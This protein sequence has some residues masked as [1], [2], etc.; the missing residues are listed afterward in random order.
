MYL[1]PKERAVGSALSQLGL[2]VGAGLAPAFTVY[3]AYHHNWRWAFFCA[4]ILGLLWIPIWLFTSKAIPPGAPPPAEKFEPSGMIADPRLW[5]LMIANALS[6]VFYTLWTNWAPTY[7]VR[8]HHLTPQEAA[9]YSWVVPLCGYVGAFVGGSMSWRYISKGGFTPVAARTRVCLFCAAILVF[10]AGI[11]LL[12]TPLLA[13]VGM[14][15]SYFLISAWS[16]NL[17]TI[18][19]DIYGAERAAFGV[20]ALVFAYGVLQAAVSRP[21][22]FVIEHYGFQPVLLTFALLPLIAYGILAFALRTRNDTADGVP[23]A[24]A[25]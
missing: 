12:T 21:L 23:I 22:G 5:G 25:T 15:L 13:T 9:H 3:F 7:L 18:P 8:V 2:S 24:V 4:G 1:L 19:V 20:S 17:Y 11:P 16:T 14:S 10:S 6:M